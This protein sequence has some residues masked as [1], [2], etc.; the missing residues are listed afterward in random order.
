MISLILNVLTVIHFLAVGG[1]ALYGI[2][3]IWMIYCWRRQLRTPGRKGSLPLP[4]VLPMVTVQLPLYNES[5]VAGRLIDAVAAFDWPAE[6]L[7]IQVLDDSTDGTRRVVDERVACW[8]SRGIDIYAVRRRRRMSYK[9]GALANGLRRAKGDLIAIFDADFVPRPDFL[10]KMIPHFTRPDIGMVQATWGFLNAGYSWLTRL[11]SLLLSTHFGIEH[12]VRF[13]RGLFFNFNGTA[14]IWRKTAIESAGGWSSD[15]VTE[16][17]DLSYRAQMAR[18]RFAY[19]NDVIVPSELPVTLSDFRRQQERWGKGAIQTAKKL[20]PKLMTSTVPLAIKIEAAAHLLANFCWIFAFLATITLYPVLLNRIGIGFYQILWLDIPLFLLTGIAVI[21]YYMVYG[22]RT[23]QL[24]PLWVLPV[25]P[26]ASIGLAP[27][28]SLAV[29]RGL[30]QKGGV[31]QRTPKFGI[32]DG[33][34]ST[35]HSTFQS[36]GVINL[37]INLPLLLYTLVPVFFAWQRGTWPAIPFLFFFPLGFCIVMASDLRELLQMLGKPV[38]KPADTFY[39]ATN[40]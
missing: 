30:T 25:L 15:T 7:E 9:A 16:D 20:L 26:A 31:F 22:L 40:Y 17:L 39:Q 37:M 36:Q 8:S 5:L 34:P 2:H 14:G 23:R 3:R 1:L 27:F 10:Q 33:I 32:T 18:W 13:R 38:N 12:E 4:T 11:Q 24:R 35:F 21:A 6:K 19:A 29:I 28:F